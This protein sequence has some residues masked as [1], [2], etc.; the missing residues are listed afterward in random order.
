MTYFVPSDYKAEIR[1]FKRE[2]KFSEA[3]NLLLQCI[4]VEEQNI[5]FENVSPIYYKELSVVLKNLGEIDLSAHYLEMY[6]TT[7]IRNYRYTKEIHNTFGETWSRSKFP[8]G[9][10]VTQDTI[11]V[12]LKYGLLE[13]LI[14]ASETFVWNYMNKHGDQKLPKPKRV[15][16][17]PL[18]EFDFIAL[19][20]ETANR[21][22]SSI[23]QIGIC[24]VENGLVKCTLRTHS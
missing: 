1:Q 2:G 10:P 4:A 8:D 7:L 22:K 21:D 13:E 15:V 5:P 19:D 18:P 6:E 3:K 11:R 12:F 14:P 23:C 16:I 24:I 20:V 9:V 17:P